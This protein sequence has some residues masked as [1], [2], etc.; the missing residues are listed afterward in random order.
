MPAKSPTGRSPRRLLCHRMIKTQRSCTMLRLVRKRT[1]DYAEFANSQTSRSASR[2]TSFQRATIS[3]RPSKTFFRPVPIPR[4]KR[5]RLTPA[6]RAATGLPSL[7]G[8]APGKVRRHGFGEWRAA[9]GSPSGEASAADELRR[10]LSC[11][12]S[13]QGSEPGYSRTHVVWGSLQGSGMK[14]EDSAMG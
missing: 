7:L 11:I 14:R 8:R 13:L 4:H 9:S 6:P 3:L 10:H 12:T 5:S 2:V 1:S